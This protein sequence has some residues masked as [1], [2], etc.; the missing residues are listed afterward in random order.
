MNMEPNKQ[1]PEVTFI[2]LAV[3]R[4]IPPPLNKVTR[5]S[6]YF[7]LLLF[8]GLPFVGGWIGYEYTPD[9][10]TEVEIE[11]EVIKKVP[12]KQT[13]VIEPYTTE[14]GISLDGRELFSYS[15][16]DFIDSEENLQTFLSEIVNT[17]ALNEMFQM[18]GFYR[19]YEKTGWGEIQQQC[20]GLKL[21]GK[22]TNFWHLK[23]LLS[24]LGGNAVNQIEDKALVINLP[25]DEI[26]DEDK[27][28]IIAGEQVT[29]ELS[30]REPTF[31]AVGPCYS[32]FEFKRI[33]E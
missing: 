32:E 24:T 6:K 33:I 3:S 22:P 21:Q 25:W 20:H 7:A 23:T 26:T 29:M 11:K 27:Q 12:I 16:K 19:T 1:L 10:V 15:V 9:K 2:P 31:S 30:A 8:I 18:T 13:A 5:T 17:Y 28:T 4:K 14:S